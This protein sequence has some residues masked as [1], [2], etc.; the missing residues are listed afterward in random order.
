MKILIDVLKD[1]KAHY[2]D[3][4]SR[5]RKRLA[6]VPRGCV[7][8]R[9]LRH[10]D[11]YYLFLRDGGRVVS[12]YLGK[13]E[14]VELLKQIEERKNLLKRLKDV[15]QNLAILKRLRWEPHAR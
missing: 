7:Q 14:P 12:K 13:D 10:G 2:L 15:R 1:S 9:R 5:V 3:V 11:Y 8:K 6:Q 4:E